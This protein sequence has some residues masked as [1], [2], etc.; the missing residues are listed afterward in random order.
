[1]RYFSTF[2]LGAFLTVGGLSQGA[3]Y[4]TADTS[5]V[6]MGM[7][8][9]GVARSADPAAAFINP[10][11][12]LFG[13]GLTLSGG[14]IMALPSIKAD[15]G[16]E[17][18]TT[19]DSLSFPPNLH[20]AYSDETFA[21][22]ASFTV[23]FGSGIK[24]PEDWDYR[25]DIVSA[26]MRVLRTSAFVGARYGMVSVAAGPNLDIGK[27]G[28]ERSIDFISDEG[29]VDIDTSAIALGGH[30]GIFVQPLENLSFGLS[31]RSASSFK[32]EGSANFETPDEF[33]SRATNGPVSTSLTM[34]TRWAFGVQWAPLRALE[35]AAEVEYN[36]WSSV[37]VL[38]IDFQDPGTEDVEKVRDWSDTTAFRFGA[39]YDVDDGLALRGGVFWDPSPVSAASVGVDSPDSSRLGLSLG[40]GLNLSESLGIDVGYQYLGFQ[41]A[42]T[43]GATDQISFEGQAHLM[44]LAFRYSGA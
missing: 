12:L 21:A 28:L 18:I 22:G 36:Q 17:A 25:F 26:E 33:Q 42:Q 4:T 20:I 11:A 3:G 39:A 19:E 7:A 10:A 9:T 2:V 35:L 40:V 43:E 15:L 16:S 8:G 29:K 13:K 41:G 38:L 24:W 1:M 32:F 5:V 14:A 23:P 37:D 30:A 44:G 34:P 27:L 31:F 6:S